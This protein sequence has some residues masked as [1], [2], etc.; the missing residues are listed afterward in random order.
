MLTIL[1][2]VVT[3]IKEGAMEV[4]YH[5]HYLNLAR[6]DTYVKGPLYHITI[7]SW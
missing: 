2:K 4:L 1:R 6:I 3:S 7:L 5:L